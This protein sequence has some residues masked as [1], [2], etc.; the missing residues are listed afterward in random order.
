M[1]LKRGPSRD[2]INVIHFSR[3]VGV[4]MLKK[5]VQPLFWFLGGL[6]A[7]LTVLGVSHAAVSGTQNP[8]PVIRE[9]K[10][11]KARIPSHL[12]Q[13]FE[14]LSRAEGKYVES[15]EQVSRLRKSSLR[16]SGSVIKGKSRGARQ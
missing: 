11:G 8:A 15:P 7:G 16:A 1:F 3:P 6:F 12:E 10:G 2:H 14:L 5:E 13:E 9:L 4:F